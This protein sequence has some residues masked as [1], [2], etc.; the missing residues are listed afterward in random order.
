MKSTRPS[1]PKTGEL[2]GLQTVFKRTVGIL[3]T[4]D[5]VALYSDHVRPAILQNPVERSSQIS[6][7]GSRGVV[8]IIRED[9]EDSPA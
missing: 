5:I 9:F 3:R 8:R 4:P 7:A 2:K 6:N 1:L